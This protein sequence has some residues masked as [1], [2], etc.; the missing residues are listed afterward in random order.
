MRFIHNRLQAMRKFHR[1]RLPITDVPKPAGIKIEQLNT[2][3]RRVANHMPHNNIVHVSP[4]GPSIIGGQWVC[5]I[6]PGILINQHLSN[7]V[8]EH[9]RGRIRSAV[10]RTEKDSGRLKNFTRLQSGAEFT[11][12][13]IEADL[14]ANHSVCSGKCH[15]RAAAELNTNVNPGLYSFGMLYEHVGYDLARVSGTG[16]RI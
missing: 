7:P 6:F 3:L 13:R 14:A 11:L 5:G 4:D 10:S 16:L 1:I 9:I 12:L 8:P 15:T 2:E